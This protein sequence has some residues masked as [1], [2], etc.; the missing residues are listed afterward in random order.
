[1]NVTI[2]HGYSASNSGDGLL[3]DLAIAL[4]HRNFGPET[5]INVVAS[6]PES[7]SYLP[8]ERYDAPVMAAKGLGRVKQAVF[9]NQSYAGLAQLLSKSDLIVGVGGGYMRSKSAFEHIKLKLGHAKQLETAILSKVPSVYLPQSIGPFH[10]ESSDIVKHYASADAVFVRDNR[11]SAIFESNENVYRAPDLAVQALASKIL[12]QP[13]FTRCASSPAVV[14]VVLR[15][16]PQWSKEKKASYVA[17]LQLLLRRLRDKCKVVCAVQSAV[18]GN[19][20]GA[21]YRE[22]GITEDLLPLKAT[23]AKYQPD[24]VISVRLHGAIESLLSGVPAFHISYERK[25]FGAYQDMGVEDWVINGGDINVDAIIDTVFAPNALSRF[26]KKLTDTCKE[27][28]GK[29]V[30][31]DNII[32]GIVR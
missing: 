32:K 29:A 3:V 28:E 26:G 7:F 10:G 24:L 25:G 22:L 8:Y 9:L 21:F 4:V 2:L 5:T 31:M 20:D 6:D 11:S 30:Q 27:I 23:L 18:R 16:P 1:M 14:C 17:N 13:K 12:A 19:D 15:K